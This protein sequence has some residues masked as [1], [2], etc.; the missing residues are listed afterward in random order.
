VNDDPLRQAVA[1]VAGFLVADAPLGE[2]LDRI[3]GHAKEGIGPADAVGMT[4]LDEKGRAT[5]TQIF[6]DDLSPEVDQAQ[7]DEDT[8]PCL[9]ALRSGEII[10][11]EDTSVVADRWPAFSTR[12]AEC[13]VHSTLSVPL[14]AGGTRIGVMNVY[15]KDASFRPDDEEDGRI[16]ATQAAAV[17]A[18]TRMY[19]GALDLAAGLQ[20][21]METRGIIEMAKGKIMAANGCTADDAFALLVK[22]SQRENLKLRDLARRIVES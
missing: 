12:A 8:G 10:R 22:A 1:A 15:S 11:V 9:D 16:F 13:G 21:A 2:T 19:W 17:L 6:T 4:L 3:A 18:N 14:D 7:Y 5:R 20:A